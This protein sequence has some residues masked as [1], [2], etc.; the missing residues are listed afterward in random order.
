M[1]RRAYLTNRNKHFGHEEQ[2]AQPEG[3]RKHSVNEPCT[4]GH[5]DE[6]DRERAGKIKHEP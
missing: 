1:K 3:Q 5:R 6:R 2:D 4:N